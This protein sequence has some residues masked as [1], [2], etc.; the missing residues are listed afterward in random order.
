MVLPVFKY[1]PDPLS[2]GSVIESTV[3]C[4]CCGQN[5]GYIYTSS[6]YAIEELH[7][8]ICPWCIAD[9]SAAKK[10]GATFVDSDPLYQAVC[11]ELCKFSGRLVA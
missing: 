4:K 8:E 7:N 2:T 1:H 3:V 5:K 6:V 9:G 10:Y 11:Q